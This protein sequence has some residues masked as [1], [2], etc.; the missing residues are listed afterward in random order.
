MAKLGEEKYKEYQEMLSVSHDYFNKVE[1]DKLEEHLKFYRNNQWDTA[2][3]TISPYTQQV[4]DNIIFSNIRT[5]MPSINFNRP[6]IFVKAKKKPFMTENNEIFDTMSGA[7]LLEILLNWYYKEL[8]TKRQTD[9]C[10]MDALI[11]FRGIMFNAYALETEAINDNNEIIKSESPYTIRIGPE[12]FRFDPSAKDAHLTDARWIAIKW[13]GTL[14][15]ARK[16]Y[17]NTQGLKANV[18]VDTQFD[19][20]GKGATTARREERH[21]GAEVWDRVEVWNIW[22]KQEEKVISVVEGHD[23]AI[24]NVEWPIDYDGGFPTEVLYF[25]ENPSEP[26]PISDVEIYIDT[27]KEL[28]RLR[29][30]Q[31]DHVRRISQRKYEVEKDTLNADQKQHL[32]HGGDG[33]IVEVDRV[34]KIV[35]IPDATISQDIWIVARDLKASSREESGVSSFREGWSREVRYRY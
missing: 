16:I 31:L 8:D 2:E 20:K 24:G 18:V 13:V 7:V 26:T 27:Q 19:S 4:T 14:E 28:N 33:T 21:E 6:K 9:K 30:L 3:G 22:D 25:N 17:P 34:G 1:K 35:P 5:I 29:S 15:E 32:T 23:K 11:G 12:D 10:I